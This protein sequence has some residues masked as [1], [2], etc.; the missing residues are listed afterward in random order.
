M[1]DRAYALLSIKAL[2]AERRL[3][4]GLASTPTPDRRGDILEPL[5]ATF[6][7][8]L[9]LLLHHDR[10]RP[11]GRV[12]LTATPAGIA[13]EA[14][15][16]DIAEPGAVRDRVNEA[17]HSIKA[18]LIPGVSIGFRPL[19]DG[20]KALASGGLHLLK[21]EICELSLVTVPANVET[22]IQTIKSFERPTW[23]R[24]ASPRPASRACRRKP[25]PDG[26]TDR[27]RT[28]PHP[29]KQARRARRAHGRDHE[30]GRRGRRDARRRAGRRST[31]G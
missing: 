20:V 25:R 15:L 11:V 12:T 22:T 7:N 21:T 6:T 1:L 18:G 19:A 23:P 31:T 4:T 3:I 26:Q 5:G 29:G 10:E 27:R 13:F 9:P 28:H 30:R 16:P 8:P 17:W 24:L 14:T 2:D